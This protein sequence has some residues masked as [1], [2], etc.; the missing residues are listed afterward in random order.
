M[1]YPSIA[2]QVS[3]LLDK[4]KSRAAPSTR[5]SSQQQRA[6]LTDAQLLDES[7]HLAHSSDPAQLLTAQELVDRV[8]TTLASNRQSFEA[9]MCEQLLFDFQVFIVF[10]CSIFVLVLRRNVLIFVYVLCVYMYMHVCREV[11]ID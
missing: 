10:N 9:W 7:L 5:T 3:L 8:Q 6:Q 11:A 2:S 4:L 1:C